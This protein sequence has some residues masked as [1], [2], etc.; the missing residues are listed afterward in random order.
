MQSEYFL[1]KFEV[2]TLILSHLPGKMMTRTVSSFVVGTKAFRNDALK[3][4]L[5]TSD[6]Y[7]GYS[8]LANCPLLAKRRRT[9]QKIDAQSATVSSRVRYHLYLDHFLTTKTQFVS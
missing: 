2:A 4:T 8:S 1:W 5:T 3:T 9:L 7:V 6:V